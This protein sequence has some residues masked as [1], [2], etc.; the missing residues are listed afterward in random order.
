MSSGN[1]EGQIPLAVQRGKKASLLSVEK[2][3]KARAEKEK[4]QIRNEGKIIRRSP[5]GAEKKHAEELAVRGDVAVFI[6]AYVIFC[7]DDGNGYGNTDKQCTDYI[8]EQSFVFWF[9]SYFFN[10]FRGKIYPHLKQGIKQHH[11]AEAMKYAKE[12]EPTIVVKKLSE[13]ISKPG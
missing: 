13:Q 10:D 8:I 5:I 11:K 3:G 7:M 6:Q 1:G 9:F 2:L 4:A 12:N